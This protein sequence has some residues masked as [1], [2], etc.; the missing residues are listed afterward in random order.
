MKISSRII[1]YFLILAI[2]PALIVGYLGH[3]TL[4][5]TET[6]VTSQS[7]EALRK[8]A[9]ESIRQKA[10]DVARQV[11][12]YIIS[13]PDETISDFQKNSEL[14]SI[15]CQK[16]GETGYTTLWEAHT[17]IVRFH[18]D[19]SL[20]NHDMHDFETRI[21]EFWAVFEKSLNG[22]E[23]EGYYPWLDP[24]SS[25]REKFMVS[26]P[27]QSP[28]HDVMLIVSATTYIDEFYQPLYSM[29]ATIS[30]TLSRTVRRQW[31]LMLS[32]AAVVMV[33]A[34]TVA[35]RI[36]SPLR[37]LVK[38]AERVQR[39]QLDQP[40]SVKNND[41]LGVLAGV[42]NTMMN[43]VSESNVKLHD[44]A[45][46][47]EKRLADII[48][49]IPDATFVIDSK[50]KV[51]AW[52]QAME[53]M[54]GIESADMIG[55]GNYEYALPFYGERRPILIDLVLQPEEEIEKKY[56]YLRKN[57]RILFGE[58]YTP[59]LGGGGIF[60]TATAA[61]LHDSGGNI[62]GAIECIRDVTDHKRAEE[63]LKESEERLRAIAE[64]AKDA[65]I[66]FDNN[67]NITYWNPAACEIF[68]YTGS[69]ALGCNFIQL[70]TPEQ[71]QNTFRRGF[72]NFQK[73]GRG[74]TFDRTFEAE[75]QRKD[76][77][78]FPAEISMAGIKIFD[79]WH[80]IAILRDISARKQT[81]WELEKAKE[82]AEV[83]NRAKSA[84]L[85]MMSHE[86]RTPMNAII[87][88]SDLLLDGELSLQHRDF[89]ET[90]RNSGGI[91]L[92]IINDILDFSKIEA[93]KLE[94]EHRSF[95][96]RQCVDSSLEI[97][98]HHA[99]S[100]GI[101][102]DCLIDA[103]TPTYI[104][105]DSTRLH[106]IL[107]NL[108]GNAV[109][110]TEK[111]E[112]TVTVHSR[113][114]EQ[115]AEPD[116]PGG[117][118]QPKNRETQWY[119]LKFSIS[120]TGIGIPADLLHRLFQPF[121]QVDSST[122]RK[123]GGTGL[124]LTISKRLT[125]MMGGKI[126]VESEKGKGSTFHFTI[127]A[128]ACAGTKPVYLATHQPTLTGKRLLIVDDLPT[129][130]EILSLQTTSWGMAPFCASS[131]T[132]A[133]E[134][135][136]RKGTFDLIIL[137]LQ[138]P[139]MDGLSLSEQI[140]LLPE[141]RSV[142]LVLL[143]SSAE[144]IEPSYET[145]FKAIL[146]KPVKASRLY[147]TL[148]DIFSPRGV[149]SVVLE[150]EEKLSPFDSQMGI[151]N[152]LRILLAEDNQSNQ[153]LALIMLDRLGY[154]ADVASNGREAVAALLRRTYDVVLM[155]IQMPEMDG[156]EAT[157]E[158]RRMLPDRQPRII[159]MT[160]DA[161]D[162]DRRQCLEAGMDD[163]LSKPVHV[164]DLVAALAGSS[165]GETSASTTPC[166]EKVGG[167]ERLSVPPNTVEARVEH[168]PGE[169][170]PQS[171]IIDRAALKRVKDMLGKQAE[172]MFP[173]LLQDFFDD[174]VRLLSDAR[175]AL[176]EKKFTE[177]RRAAHTLKSTSAT[178]G[179]MALSA[180]SKELEQL[181]RQETLEGAS[182]LI[183]RAEREYKQAKEE[184]EHIGRDEK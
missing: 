106:Q 26:T 117:G 84:F 52:N 42:F 37:D 46:N 181:A 90:I 154:R 96:I 151:R 65:I 133:L 10:R 21:P 81:E 64:T 169:S 9:E 172:T 103:H 36:T 55:R 27:V 135:L 118:S 54:T 125:E 30:Q 142:P 35:R 161:M 136:K 3:K 101:E 128:Q 53:K 123:Y 11:E 80:A 165:A 155:D 85:A 177:L 75:L 1:I 137:D 78:R 88:M 150:S 34:F 18:P 20:I 134:L 45:T 114:L 48:D 98:A 89:V 28:V 108:I 92:S 25:L 79:K 71:Y 124:G 168:S 173:K 4:R 38:G 12:I 44:Y 147:D 102:L 29:Q 157:R 94:L 167:Q 170:P 158:I 100:K 40:V 86:I 110:F 91:L 146:L 115:Q 8:Q 24:D 99:R 164:H 60:L 178:F 174:G 95:D 51:I 67:G 129:N 145:R 113:K 138:M 62:F 33:F 68:K 131:G 182:E 122:T 66:M 47:L 82:E 141:R 50:G 72:S 171:T 119:E 97:F 43:S 116:I 175:R 74:P 56:V 107:V 156:L 87:G 5:E 57:G 13:H 111:G 121:T 149:M 61:A 59:S 70:I 83:A 7:S 77:C 17:A 19:S 63:A 126:E 183:E 120:D 130:R 127:Q 15:A 139:D 58:A 41:E 144:K 184:L 6:F 143:T 163:Y 31:F 132:E 152:P 140:L 153:K 76:G 148:I 23:S 14:A 39:G 73:T 112:I 93:G 166:M 16:V 32:I 179:A 22:H 2:T 105:G 176:E 159:A 162:E 104:M 160:A 180:V 109:K 49:F 69:D